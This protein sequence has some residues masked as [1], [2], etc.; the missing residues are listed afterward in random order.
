M[1]TPRAASDW[2]RGPFSRQVLAVFSMTKL[3]IIISQGLVISGFEFV[4]PSRERDQVYQTEAS[5]GRAE[6]FCSRLGSWPPVEIV[7]G[8]RLD[9]GRLAFPGSINTV[10]T[11]R[12][13]TVCT[14]H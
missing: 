3:S 11:V 8:I 1:P 6:L 9:A 10:Y 2:G 7:Y 5:I 13:S 14:T 4:I 12:L